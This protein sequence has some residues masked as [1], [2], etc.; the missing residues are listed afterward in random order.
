MS[1][2]AFVAAME[3]WDEHPEGREAAANAEAVAQAEGARLGV[4]TTWLRDEIAGRR[5]DGQTMS[6]AVR[7]VVAE[8]SDRG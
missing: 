1:I 3:R 7:G 5:R 2:E 4:P 8:A 6:R